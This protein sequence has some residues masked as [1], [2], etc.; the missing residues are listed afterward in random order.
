MSVGV[1]DTAAQPI[2]QLRP[3]AGAQ[4][5]SLAVLGGT[6][7]GMPAFIEALR[8]SQEQGRL[9]TIDVRLFGRDSAKLA[10]VH[11][12]I[13][14]CLRARADSTCAE[15]SMSVH[16]QLSEALEGA[17]HVVCVVRAGGMAGRARDE[18]LARAA[19]VPADE[20]IAVGGLACFLRGREVI[21]ALAAQCRVSAPSAIFLQMSSP[22][23]LNVA[24]TRDVFGSAAY[25][26]CELPLVTKQTVL[27]YV[28][29]RLQR[30]CVS[31]RSAGLN[32]QSWL[33]AFT[34][35]VGGDCTA[36]VLGAIDTATLVDV[37]PEIIRD[38]GAVP[39][40]YLR[41]YLHTER[42]L[43]EQARGRLRGSALARWSNRLDCAF[44]C[45]S[46]KT[47]DIRALLGQRRMNWFRDGVLPVLEAF[48]NAEES[49]I[50]LNVPCAGALA[51]IPPESI[52]EIDCSVSSSGAA[53]LPAPP[54][55]V[56]PLALTR[57]LATYERAVLE[58]PQ[59][60]TSDDLAEVLSM[61]PLAPAE[62]VM[63]TAR[64]LSR[65]QPETLHQGTP[66]H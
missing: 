48:G 31:A 9:G 29:P 63:R 22:L 30:K 47:E 61:H 15:L 25:G 10:G 19:G 27:R 35:Q 23:G 36:E 60:P 46:A 13:E 5:M 34:D 53:A 17:T 24:I 2:G 65:I 55:P 50:P 37:E 20:G 58:L 1:R 26:V 32:H 45:N 33:Y 56:K 52:I 38:F 62:G 40:P 59:A 49:C 6:S 42:V 12:Y 18:A 7:S 41:L 11:S 57:Q 64:A 14:C 21:R 3:R 51:N 28:A 54:L 4:R 39:V 8:T 66:V 44:R 16:A 43:A